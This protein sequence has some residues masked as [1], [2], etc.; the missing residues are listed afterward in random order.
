MDRCVGAAA[1]LSGSDRKDLAI[2]AFQ[3]NRDA[4]KRPFPVTAADFRLSSFRARIAC[5]SRGRMKALSAPSSLSRRWTQARQFDRRNRP[6]AER[7][8]CLAYRQ[9]TSARVIE[10]DNSL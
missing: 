8:Q 7:C 3:P 2:Q 10:S 5:S 9:Q 1:K 6:G 4:V